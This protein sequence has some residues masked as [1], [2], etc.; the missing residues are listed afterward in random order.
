MTT[1]IHTDGLTKTYGAH[2]G[3]TDL[4]LDVESGEIFGFLGPN[5]AGKTTTMRI[6]LDL[7]RP[8]AGR[9]EVFGIE[10]TADPV[11]IHRRVG[12]LP[13]EFDLYD[14]LTGGRH[15]RLLREPARRRRP[16]LRRR[17]R[18]A[19]GPRPEPQVQGV[20]EGQQAEGRPGRRPP[21]PARPAHPRRA[22]VR[23]S[24]RSSSRPSSSSS[25][26]REAEGRTVFLSSH[27]I[28][29]V[30]RTCDRVAIIREG[31]LVQVDRIEAIRQL[32]FHHVELTLRAARRGGRLR[33]D[34]R[35]E[36]GRRRGRPRPDARQRPDRRGHRRGRPA[37]AASTSSA[38]SRTSRTSFLAQ[39]GGHGHVRPP[40]GSTMRAET[41]ALA[42][43]TVDAVV[44]GHGPD[45]RSTPRPSATAAGR[46]SSSA[47]SAGCSCSPRPRPTAT[48][49]ATP[50][51]R[52]QLVAQMTSL[53]AVF[54][55]LLGGPIN[56]DTLGGYMSCG[57]ATS[58]PCMLGLWSVL[59][60]SGTLAGEAARGSLDL[61]ASTP[62]RRRAIAAPEARRPRHGAGRR[63]SLIAVVLTWLAGVAFATLP[64]DEIAFD[65]GRSGCAL[66]VG[67]LIAGLRL[68]R[69][70]PRARSSD[71]RAPSV[72]GMVVL[73]G[74]YVL[75]VYATAVGRHRRRSR[76]CRG[77][78]G[79]PDHR[80][81]AG[82]IDW[83]SVGAPRGGHRRPPGHRRRRPSPGATSGGTS[84]LAGVAPAGPAG[85]DPRADRRASSADRAGLAIGLG[86]GIGRVR[87]GSSPARR[88][89]SPT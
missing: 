82:V 49:F 51:A 30:E 17:A 63:R 65:G 7:I 27:I 72:V 4:D 38:A 28:D 62:D 61:V 54:Q 48:E 41:T 16:R 89:S 43:P 56:V 31:R 2:R 64:G 83:A 53:P 29:E 8:T 40:P 21:A 26:R 70:R 32:A 79:P 10:T 9:A 12:Y 59:A 75:D 22:D 45:A 52:A 55:G 18:R 13:G 25:A 57:S 88:P 58:F 14:R 81:L 73:F 15:D 80:P 50:E 76:R 71:G 78:T 19:P 6:L 42:R 67:L 36:R 69:L 5:G 11:A 87:R 34:R 1:V 23:V 66:L 33:A 60:L 77:S 24:T 84:A 85:R 39:Y 74:G 46:R 44:A 68:G 20:L 35:R 37:R 86:L 47:A 3:I